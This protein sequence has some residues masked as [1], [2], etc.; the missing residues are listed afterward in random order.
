M[1]KFIYILL[2]LFFLL[3]S[4]IYLLI[5]TKSGNLYIANYLEKSF[6]SKQKDVTLKIDNFLITFK[7]ITV[8][9]RVNEDSKLDI[10]GK[11][12]VFKLDVDFDYVIDIK[13]LA[14]FNHITNM[15][16]NA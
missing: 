5:F 13:N 16:L 4:T 2:L 3:I 11:F 1:K 9:A 7:N 6:N 14:D 12:D 10:Q 8:N 15:N